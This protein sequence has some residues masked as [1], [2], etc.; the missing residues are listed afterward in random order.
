MDEVLSQQ[1]A[2]LQQSQTAFFVGGRRK[3]ACFTRPKLAERTPMLQGPFLIQP[4][5]IDAS[6]EEVYACDIIHTS[7]EPAAVLAT[8]WSDGNVDISLEVEPIVAKWVSK[9][10]KQQK[11]QDPG[12]L[13]V[14]AC[15]ETATL[16]I[17]LPNDHAR[18]HWPILIENPLI[19]AAVFIVHYGGVDGIDM[20]GWLKGLKLV[21][22]EAEGEDFIAKY[23]QRAQNSTITKV[24]NSSATLSALP[25]PII[26][27]AVIHDSYVGF[28]LLAK[29]STLG[30]AA[31]FDVPLQFQDPL[32]IEGPLGQLALESA[33]PPSTPPRH[34]TFHNSDTQ[35]TLSPSQEPAAY[36]P[37]I[38]DTFE[39]PP[40]LSRPPT[41]GD[42]LTDLR[43]S[44]PYLL[45]EHIGY[46]VETIDVLRQA[47]EH[48]KNEV[49]K[50]MAVS[51]TLCARARLQKEEYARQIYTARDLVE[52]NEKLDK[53]A[54]SDRLNV[55]RDRQKK[56]NRRADEIIKKLVVGGLGV[57]EKGGSVELSERE[58]EWV[59]EIEMLEKRLSTMR[60]AGLSSRVRRVEGVLG[61]L[62]PF[63][64][65]TE[66]KGDERSEQG[67]D[68]SV[69][70]ELREKKLKE[71]MD[72]L[73]TGYASPSCSIQHLIS[74]RLGRY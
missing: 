26:G 40:F 22:D 27:A 58:V 37:S 41:L 28:A 73:A 18:Q 12:D 17:P 6:S 19:E 64:E 44:K 3:Q 13:P 72:L 66:K 38:S 23:I 33:G 65:G 71:L 55:A 10:V 59:A 52:R 35:A 15:F 57:G 49:E 25:Q 70:K 11:A 61:E 39:I 29:S 56:L 42:L 67:R 48:I 5:P 30:Y 7:P 69:P 21:L 43:R 50:L 34:S 46:N 51:K 1:A 60:S 54:L 68:D 24:V 2:M 14:I 32:D 45:Q 74:S 4:P 62:L 53:S 20:S 31:E 36:A 16:T 8:V 63:V 9:K 47:R